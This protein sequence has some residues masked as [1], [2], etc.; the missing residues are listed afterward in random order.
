[1][2]CKGGCFEHVL[3]MSALCKCIAAFVCV[4]LVLQAYVCVLCLSALQ[5]TGLLIR[6][7]AWTVGAIL[8]KSQEPKVHKGNAS[9]KI[10][11]KTST[12]VRPSVTNDSLLLVGLQFPPTHTH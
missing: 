3:R 4:Y 12:F 1:M 11:I 10:F 8:E 2:K 5:T 7:D 9:I 6:N